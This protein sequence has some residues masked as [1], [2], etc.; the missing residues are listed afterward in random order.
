V[1]PEALHLNRQRAL[2]LAELAAFGCD[3]KGG[4]NSVRRGATGAPDSMD[5]VLA[6]LEV[7]VDHVGNIRNVERAGPS[8]ATSTRGD[9]FKL[10][11]AEF[12]CDCNGRHESAWRT[13]QNEV[14]RRATRSA[15]C[16]VRNEDRK[17]AL[18]RA[19]QVLEEFL[20]VV[21]LHFKWCAAPHFPRA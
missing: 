18:L 12:R 9:L 10:R 20:L 21:L 19:Q 13:S 16:L 8:V 6:N 15:P 2:D 7:V 14:S 11:S 1:D 4:S 17:A 5:E 3:G